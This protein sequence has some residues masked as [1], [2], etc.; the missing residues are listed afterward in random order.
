MWFVINYLFNGE[1]NETLCKLGK[2][3]DYEKILSKR[4]KE[5][6]IWNGPLK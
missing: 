5:I 6:I 2:I 4:K 3:C 1:K